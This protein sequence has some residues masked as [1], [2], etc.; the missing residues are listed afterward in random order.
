MKITDVIRNILDIIDSAEGQPDQSVDAMVVVE[1]QTD[2]SVLQ[3]LAGLAQEPEYANEP[4]EIV[5]G[6]GA[7][8]PNGDDMHHSKNPADIRTNAP[9]MYP[10]YQAEKK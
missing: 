6:I 9:S 2:L 5:A 4:N 10:G 3:Q 8:F 1:P 7:A